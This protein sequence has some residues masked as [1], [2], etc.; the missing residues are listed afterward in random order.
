M[1]KSNLSYNDWIY[2]FDKAKAL[3]STI[4]LAGIRGK[5]IGFDETLSILR[6]IDIPL[7]YDLPAFSFMPKDLKPI[8]DSSSMNPVMVDINSN[9]FIV[10]VQDSSEWMV[11]GETG[12]ITYI[13]PF[14]SIETN[15]FHLHKLYTKYVTV[16]SMV[17][18]APSED[19]GS[20]KNS[21][22][23]A[24]YNALKADD[25]NLVFRHGNHSLVLFYGWFKMSKGD[26]IYMSFYDLPGSINF[27]TKIDIVK[28][29]TKET[30]STYSVNFNII[31]TVPF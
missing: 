1:S 2:I 28:A 19:L 14:M 22:I 17:N 4:V 9:Q 30:I 6:T 13:Y 7:Y 8:Y 5:L 12:E 24:K 3:K 25:G 20:M 31:T 11:D 27:V 26:D 16:M 10:E 21:D 15:P 23:I 18:R 29:K